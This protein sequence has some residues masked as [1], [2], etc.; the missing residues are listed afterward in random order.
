[1]QDKYTPEESQAMIDEVRLGWPKQALALYESLGTQTLRFETFQLIANITHYNHLHDIKKYADFRGDRMF[2]IPE[3]VAL[4]LLKGGYVPTAQVDL[5][6]FWSELRAV[7]N[8]MSKY[9][10]IKSAMIS[11]DNADQ[12]DD[13]LSRV[14]N[15]L[16]QDEILVRNPGLP[17]HHRIISKQLFSPLDVQLKAHFGFSVAEGILIRDKIVDLI[18]HRFYKAMDEALTKSIPVKEE[19]VRFRNTGYRN[20]DSELSQDQLLQFSAMKSK[21]MKK[22]VEAYFVAKIYF[23][24]QSVYLFSSA[25]LSEY[26]GLHIETTDRFL[27]H[28]S[29]TFGT[30]NADQEIVAPDSILKSRPVIKYGKHHIVPSFPLLTWCV[31]PAFEKYINSLPKLAAKYKDVKHDY[32]LEEGMRLLSSILS[33][34]TI[35]PQNLFYNTEEGKCETDGLIG[36]DR[37]L[38]IIEAKGHRLSQ[39][40]KDGSYQRTEKHLKQIIRDSTSQGRRTKK[41][42]TGS[43][44]AV[45]TTQNGK[46]I[47]V[48]PKLYD[49][50]IIVSL[51]LEPLGHLIPLL[52]VTNDLDYFGGGVFPWIISIYDLI[53]IADHMELPILLLHYLKR[54]KRFLEVDNINIYEEIDML[55]YFLSNGLYIENTIKDAFDKDVSWMSFDNNTD[56]IMDYYMYKFGHKQDFTPKVKFFMPE[57]FMAL[58]KGIEDSDIPH[59]TE[60]M[61]EMLQ[62]SSNSVKNLMDYIRKVKQQFNEDGMQHDCSIGVSGG[63]FGI[64][65][66]AGP[67]QKSLDQML[68]HHCNY[69]YDQLKARTWI[70]V[71]DLSTNE[72]S[73]H[74]KCSIIIKDK[75]PVPY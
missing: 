2:V 48:D 69:K 17:D 20:E 39:K 56:D 32:L 28:F 6:S 66:M 9:F 68:Y 19:V 58:L 54:R 10:A 57:D 36:Y 23:E 65:F 27:E 73:Y 64:T 74:I 70:G 53:V 15:K 40:A 72:D 49:E 12:A 46:Q 5:N 16:M 42:I 18:N 33:S 51:T 47:E 61:L 63:H 75:P 29:T 52:K 67:D 45:F 11:S 26:S 1:M 37:T 60:I 7:Q 14:T 4:Y 41:Y 71:G 62:L 59:R 55:A 30:V 50:F 21:Q 25:E 35:Y 31:E 38:F 34:A 8:T 3:L 22:E 44:L 43:D 24:L 13:T